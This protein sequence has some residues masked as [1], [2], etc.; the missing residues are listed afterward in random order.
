MVGT[1]HI[2]QFSNPIN[3][4]QK[5]ESCSTDLQNTM[6]NQLTILFIKDQ[7]F[8]KI[9]RQFYFDFENIALTCNLAKLYL[10]IRMQK[11]DRRYQRTLWGNLDPTAEPVFQ[12]NR[13]VFGINSAPFMAQFLT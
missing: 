9:L 12:F 11:D 5:S 2:F 6:V 1:Y 13:L 8:N 7:N 3:Q 10:R 4:L